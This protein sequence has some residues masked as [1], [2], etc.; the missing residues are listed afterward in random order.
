MSAL[1]SAGKLKLVLLLELPLGD[2]P[3]TDGDLPALEIE[4]RL[5]GGEDASVLVAIVGD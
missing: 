3:G 2:L 5:E 1:A 4:V